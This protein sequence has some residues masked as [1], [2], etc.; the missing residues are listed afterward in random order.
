MKENIN[1]INLGIVVFAKAQKVCFVSVFI[2]KC[3]EWVLITIFTLALVIEI[4]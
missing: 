3:K 1:H 2:R 4:L